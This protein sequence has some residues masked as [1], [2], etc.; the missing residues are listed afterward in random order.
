MRWTR[1]RPATL[2][3]SQTITPGVV[4]PVTP[5]RTPALWMTANGTN[6]SESPVPR[7][8]FAEMYGKV[9][10]RDATF[11]YISANITRGT[12]DS[13]LFVPFAVIQR[14]GVRV[15]VT[16]FT[17]PGVMVWDRANVAGR[18]RV[19]RIAAAAPAA[20]RGLEQA[21]VDFKIVL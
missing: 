15:G 9:A 12:G 19:Q 13:L 11:P 10:A 16:G 8:M 18:A 1:A 20:L 6:R 17:T 3:R 4:K 5:T 21:G 14:A 7:V 2:A